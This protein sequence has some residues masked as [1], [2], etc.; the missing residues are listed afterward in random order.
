MHG[1][2]AVRKPLLRKQNKQKRL[3]W[4]QQHKD[5][6][7]EQWK[8]VLWTDES[9]FEIYGSRRRV[10][11]RRS[12]GERVRDQCIVPTVK[13][14]GGSV[15]IWECFGGTSVGDLHKVDGI[16]RKEG[17][18]HILENHAIPSGLRIIGE[19]FVFQHDHDPK[20]TA[21]V[22]RD[23]LG[24]LQEEGIICIMEWPPQSPDLNPI[25]LL[26]HH[27][28]R[29]VRQSAP[30]SATTM[31][32]FLQEAWQQISP[33]TLAKLVDRMP[34]LCAAVIK[35]RGCYIDESRI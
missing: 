9:K 26:W 1:R 31:W 34:R 24:E 30:T 8:R 2:I 17:Y 25:E 10:F 19:N 29:T 27:L 5:W 32:T 4:A 22:C 13:H 33:L 18:K 21:K 16:L 3:N 15:M 7:I 11:V 12:A 28:D 20:Q 6:T 23:Y 14:G 35:S